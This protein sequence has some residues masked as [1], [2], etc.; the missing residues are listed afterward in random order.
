MFI[1]TILD[2]PSF[3]ITDLNTYLIVPEYVTSQ[4]KQ[5][6]ERSDRAQVDYDIQA[7]VGRN[8]YSDVSIGILRGYEESCSYVNRYISELK[9]IIARDITNKAYLCEVENTKMDSSKSGNSYGT[10][11]DT[12]YVV[13]QQNGTEFIITDM[14]KKSRDIVS[15]PAIEADKA[16][17]SRLNA[18]NLSGDVTATEKDSAK[19]LLSDW[20]TACTNR[21]L[22]VSEPYTVDGVTINY[23]MYDCFNSDTSVLSESELEYI[24]SKIRGYL[25]AK[26]VNKDSVYT[27][28]VTE[29]LGGTD[30]QVE[31]TT[32]ELITY[33]KSSEAKYLRTY[34]LIS[35]MKDKWVIDEMKILED[36]E[37]SGSEMSEI[38]GRL[39]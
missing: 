23:G 4:I 15:E 22:E 5:I 27:G 10:Y 3:A 20:Y 32:E 24:N 36:R 14:V 16:I 1:P 31:F 12:Y 29:W 39:N 6:I 33:G 28:T 11:K 17:V 13:V 8:I 7:L 35:N 37:V 9:G 19:A 18:L 2:L 25:T 38:Q 30:N 26:G 34:Y 21:I